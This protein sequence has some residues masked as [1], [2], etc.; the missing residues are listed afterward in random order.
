MHDELEA[1]Q[2]P[3]W[4]YSMTDT[5]LEYLKPLHINIFRSNLNPV[6]GNMR[7]R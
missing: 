1:E 3:S 6:D 4:W 2:K 5:N 7:S